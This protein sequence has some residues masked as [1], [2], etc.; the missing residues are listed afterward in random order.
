MK[1]VLLGIL[2]LICFC[3]YSVAQQQSQR[4]KV[5]SIIKELNEKNS[6]AILKMMADTCRIGNLP[7]VD[8]SVVVPQI[9]ASYNEITEYDIVSETTDGNNTRVA[10]SVTFDDGKQGKPSLT[11]NADHKLVNLGIISGRM[12]AQPELSLEDAMAVTLKPDSIKVPFKYV[13]GLIYVQAKLNGKVG[14]FMFDSGSPVVILRKKY[15]SDEHIKED[16]KVDFFGMG[17]AMDDVTWSTGNTLELGGLKISSLVAPVSYMDDMEMGEEMPIFGLIGQGIYNDYQ[18]T[19][20]YERLELLFERIDESGNIA[21]MSYP[22]GKALSSVPLTVKRH[23]PIV[24]LTIGNKNYA[25]G[26]DCGANANVLKTGSAKEIDEFIEYEKDEASMIG[27]GGTSTG[28]EIGF[29]MKSYIGSVPLQ[30]MFTVFTDQQIGAGSGKDA[31]PIVGLLG[32]PFLN[33]YKVTI[34]IKKGELTIYNY[35]QK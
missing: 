34:N 22:K 1:N 15:V 12:T 27:V 24:N 20:D 26:I 14:Y 33:Q 9:I 28:N 19:F 23:I 18:V 30:D 16:I 10:L 7:S 4:G 3:Q 25:M 21:G 17:G 8:N 29:V 32:T 2:G 6:L 31:L 11:F 35:H 5:A 13:S